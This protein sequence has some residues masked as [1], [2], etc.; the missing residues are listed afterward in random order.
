M[1]NFIIK[2]LRTGLIVLSTAAALLVNML[3]VTLPLNGKSTKELS[4][5]IPTYFTPAA[6]VFSVWG[7]IYIGLILFTIYRI[8]ERESGYF[9]QLDFWYVVSSF[10]NCTWIVLWHYQRVPESVLAMLMLL[11]SLI[12][13]YSSLGIGKVKVPLVERVMVHIPF[14]IYL[15]WI[16]VAT[17]A[18]IAA[19]LYVLKWDGLG[20]A[21]QIWSA[22]MIAIA[23]G[24][25]AY[26]IWT[27]RDV[28]FA[29]V[30][31]WAVIGIATK[32]SSEGII[33][34]VTFASLVILG[35]IFLLTF[36]K[37]KELA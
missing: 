27:R 35:G 28:F 5:L 15:S 3:A 37:R 4:D 12:V 26:A 21:P 20:I 32:F 34:S 10:A 30:Y 2:Y 16:S 7:I 31:V 29:G 6:Y 24:L 9:K 22:I 1:T 25:S 14:S 33:V 11:V 13:I 8:R 23:G 19:A 18:N 17:I 36:L